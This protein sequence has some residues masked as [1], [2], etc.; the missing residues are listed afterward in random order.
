MNVP[1]LRRPFIRHY[2]VSIVALLGLLVAPNAALASGPYEGWIEAVLGPDS[3]SGLH[4]GVET[5]IPVYQTEDSLVFGWG[6]ALGDLDGLAMVD[7]GLGYRMRIGD[8]LILGANALVGFGQSHHGHTR[9]RGSF[10]SEVLSESW[11]VVLEG[12]V[13]DDDESYIGARAGRP[14][15]PSS[16]EVDGHDIRMLTPLSGSR[17]ERAASGL[18]GEFGYYL[19]FGDP[20]TLE[21]R[22]FVGGFGYFPSNDSKDVGAAGFALPGPDF[23]NIIGPK[24]GFEAK[25]YDLGILG[26]AQLTLR[27]EARWDD[28]RGHEGGAPCGSG[29]RSA[30]SAG[31]PSRANAPAWI[32]A[33]SS[34]STDTRWSGR[35]ARSRSTPAS[36][37][38]SVNSP[39]ATR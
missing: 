8:G 16:I 37:P 6:D 9:I 21:V 12:Y 23:D 2:I 34:V 24:Y 29:Y 39:A 10:G 33:W 27:G 15:G 18:E 4:A 36:R 20:S 30:P 11:D 19:P 22:L 5:L 13:I 17:S 28:Q 25:L 14:I 35:G 31:T 7:G 1:R 3:W 38:S 32:A 26:G